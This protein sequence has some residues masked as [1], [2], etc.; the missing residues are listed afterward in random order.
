MKDLLLVKDDEIYTETKNR[1]KECRDKRLKKLDLSSLDLESLPPEIAELETLEELDISGFSLKKIP[2]FIGKI[3]SLKKLSFGSEND[4]VHEHEEIILPPELGN[5]RNLQHLSLGYEIPEIPEWVWNLGKLKKLSIRNNTMGQIPPTI[6]KLKNLRKLRV[7]S[8]QITGLP[9]EIGELPLTVLDLSCPQ[10]KSLP[11]SF[12]NLKKMESFRFEQCSMAAIPGFISGWTKLKVLVMDGMHFKKIPDFLGN[13]PLQYLELAGSYKTIPETFGSLLNLEVLNLFSSKSITLPPS[14][15]NLSALKKLKIHSPGLTVPGTFGRLTAL[16]YLSLFAE[17]LTLP[18]SFGGLSSLRELYIHAREMQSLPESIGRCKNLK[19]IS[20]KSDKLTRLPGSFCELKNLKKLY[21]DAFLLKELPRNF[22]SLKLLKHAKIFSGVMTALPESMANLKRLDT[23]D[24]DAHNLKKI[25]A[26][27]GKLAKAKQIHIQTGKEELS[28][29][30]KAKKNTPGFHELA[31]MS[32]SYLQ[33][34]LE[35]YTA[36]KIEAILCSAPSP[37]FNT[38]D[39]K[40]VFQSFMSERRFKMNKKFKWTEEN[41]KRIVRVSD[42]FLK[43]W[44]DGIAKAKTIINALYEKEGNSFEKAGYC[45]K[46]VLYP[47]INCCDEEEYQKIY[48]VIEEHLNSENELSIEIGC[49]PE[50]MN[51][52]RFRK[53]IHLCRDLS[54]NIEGFGETELEGHY[55]CYAMH[56]LYSHN[57]WA[58]EDILKIKRI[59]SKVKIECIIESGQT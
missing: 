34:V 42:E 20:I 33:K 2:G 39:E 30:K 22:G 26:W 50:T 46:V 21:L 35:G 10:L 27:P 48:D 13:C 57:N 54:W 32:Y 4:F 1:I 12:S 52:D 3:V 40:F 14:F 18:K 41:K 43:A 45:A 49:N 58:N 38:D 37:N 23:L 17:N 24:I 8:N 31:R 15:G 56:V 6:G 25:P 28:L 47:E 11:G 5:L 55:I 59:S 16:E 29:P 19:T 9:D 36:K 51:D 7:Y 53:S 44:E